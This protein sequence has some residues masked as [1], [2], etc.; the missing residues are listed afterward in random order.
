MDALDGNAIAGRLFAA[1]GEEMTTALTTCANC[2]M[3]S[4]VAELG[5]YLRG[6]GTVAR[7]RNCD[8][9][10]IVFTEIHGITCVGMPGVAALDSPG[11]HTAAS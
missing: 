3:R 10:L 1:F 11:E 4:V 7:C 6:P 9:A 5:A 8:N 2:G